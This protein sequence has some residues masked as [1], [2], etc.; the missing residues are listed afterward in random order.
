MMTTLRKLVLTGNPLRTLRSSLVSGPT[1]A[2]LKFLRSRLSTDEDSEAATTAKENVVTMAARLSITSKELSLE[3]MG[4]SAVPAQVW[5][6]SEIVKVDLSRNSIQELPPELTSCVSLQ[7][8]ILSRNKIQEWPGVI[9]KSLPNLSCLKLDNIHSDRRI[10][11]SHSNGRNANIIVN[12]LQLF[13][14]I[15]ADGFQAVSKLQILDLSGNS[16]SLP[17]N[18]AFSSLPQLQ[19]LYLRR[20]QLCEVPSDILSLQQLQILDL[21][22]NSLQLIPEVSCLQCMNRPGNYNCFWVVIVMQGFKNLTSLTEL[23]LSDN[24]IATLPP[25]LVWVLFISYLNMIIDSCSTSLCLILNVCCPGLL[26][27][28]LQALRLDGNPL[29]SIRRTILDRGT[30]AVLKYLKDKIP[31]H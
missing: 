21:S 2:L 30:K 18:P 31:E 19:E 10:S 5:E 6:S 25:E 1:P 14:L 28:S 7:A 8:L 13:S 23:N 17:D 3:G 22:Q 29:R 4:L 24:S 26:E 16:A 15:P 12:W 27:P 20:M 11:G 9:L